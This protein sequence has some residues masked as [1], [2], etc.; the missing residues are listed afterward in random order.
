[1]NSNEQPGLNPD[2]GCESTRCPS[3][4]SRPPET[5]A[6]TP[7]PPVHA[8]AWNWLVGGA[9]S[10]SARSGTASVTSPPCDWVT[11]VLARLPSAK[12]AAVLSRLQGV[13]GVVRLA[14]DVASDG[15]VAELECA[16]AEVTR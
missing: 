3:T 1:M 4:S 5:V 14:G 2:R 9:A 8:N 15:D 12:S 7:A 10:N 11:M 6:A 16:S 13:G